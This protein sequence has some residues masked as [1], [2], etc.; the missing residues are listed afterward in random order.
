MPRWSALM[1][2]SLKVLFFLQRRG[3]IFAV[4]SISGN[5]TQGMIRN[6]VAY[7]F[8]SVMVASVDEV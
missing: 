3:R 6:D 4:V 2:N 1:R 8:Y 5:T 7:L